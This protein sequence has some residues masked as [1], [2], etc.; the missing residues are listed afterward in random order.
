VSY[1]NYF[2]TAEVS[3]FGNY[4]LYWFYDNLNPLGSCYSN[5]FG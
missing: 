5:N 4:I 1:I 3:N 2:T